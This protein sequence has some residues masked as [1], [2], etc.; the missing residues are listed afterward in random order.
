M[1]GCEVSVSW[2]IGRRVRGGGVV[3]VG[4]LGLRL[5]LT[6]VVWTIVGVSWLC[7]RD[8]RGPS[9]CSRV[10]RVG[11]NPGL[12]RR[13]TWLEVTSTTLLDGGECDWRLAVVFIMRRCTGVVL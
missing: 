5:G 6:V 3:W 12:L 10:D 13:I 1:C 4:R 7:G 2:V 9:L 8:G 11:Q